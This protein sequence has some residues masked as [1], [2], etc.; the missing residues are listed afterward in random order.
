MTSEN[1]E[2]TRDETALGFLIDQHR[3][4]GRR[5]SIETAVF[6]LILATL[7]FLTLLP[8]LDVVR[9]AMLGAVAVLLAGLWTSIARAHWL[10]QGRLEKEIAD[11]LFGGAAKPVRT[12]YVEWRQGDWHHSRY[13]RIVRMEPLIW[14]LITVLIAAARLLLWLGTP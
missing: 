9:L 7:A 5:G 13:N 3:Q 2:S 11:L 12:A 4:L 6:R 8:R 1:R 10:S 14:G